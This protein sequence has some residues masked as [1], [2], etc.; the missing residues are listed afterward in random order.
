MSFSSKLKKK[1]LSEDKTK[2][3]NIRKW[4]YVNHVPEIN[5]GLKNRC[6]FILA[7]E[8]LISLSISRKKEKN[9]KEKREWTRRFL[10]QSLNLQI[11]YLN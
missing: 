1:K 5:S 3:P 7:G 4:G 8:N 2:F 6:T 9:A 11:E 10:R